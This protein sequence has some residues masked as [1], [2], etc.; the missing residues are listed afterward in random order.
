MTTTYIIEPYAMQDD[1]SL[2]P[3]AEGETLFIV[4]EGERPIGVELELA[5]AYSWLAQLCLDNGERLIEVSNEGHLEYQAHS[6][7][8]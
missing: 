3:D 7:A 2:F 5:D 8:E 1:G 6:I 4:F